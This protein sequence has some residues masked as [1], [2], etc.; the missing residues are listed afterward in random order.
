MSTSVLK[1][2]EYHRVAGHIHVVEL[3]LKGNAK[4]SSS[5]G[6]GATPFLYAALTDKHVRIG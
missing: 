3:L 2:C 1:L 4:I 6:N 5:D